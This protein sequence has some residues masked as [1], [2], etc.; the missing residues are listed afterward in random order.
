MNSLDDVKAWA[1]KSA[2]G[3]YKRHLTH[4]VSLNPYST[5]SA[6]DYWQR[7][8]DNKPA[9]SWEGDLS[10]NLAYQRGLAAAELVKEMK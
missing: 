10:W 4:D 9:H 6:R 2:N 5:G 1:I 8:F 3:D 7:G